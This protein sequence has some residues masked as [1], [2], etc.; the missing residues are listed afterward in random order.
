MSE[1]G[2]RKFSTNHLLGEGYWVWLIPLSTGPI[3]IGVVRRP[4]L[5]PVRGDLDA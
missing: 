5:P 4:A 1:P 3:S 2:I